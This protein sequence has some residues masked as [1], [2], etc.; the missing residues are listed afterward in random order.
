MTPGRSSFFKSISHPDVL[1]N[2]VGGR[3]ELLLSQKCSP[4]SSFLCDGIGH[5]AILEESVKI[6]QRFWNSITGRLS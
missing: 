1:S 3:A 2:W 5:G 4:I 6:D